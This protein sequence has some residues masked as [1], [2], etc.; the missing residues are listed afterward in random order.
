MKIKIFLF[1]LLT[2]AGHVNSKVDPPNYN[3]SLDSLS[4]FLP[5]GSLK[6]LKEVHGDGEVI[7]KTGE[8]LTLKY[9]IAQLRYKFPVLVVVENGK[10]LDFYATLPTY[11]VHDL[12]HQSLINRYKKQNLFRKYEGTSLYMWKTDKLILTYAA[13]CTITCFPLYLTGSDPAVTESLQ[14]MI[15]TGL[16][17]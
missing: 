2:I 3:F 4:S 6:K 1:I 9:N 12:F 14:Q 8:K 5:G 11:F 10:V 17:K 15:S 16:L 7:K 13:T